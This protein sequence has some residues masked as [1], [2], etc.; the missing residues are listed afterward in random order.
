MSNTNP[1]NAN[2]VGRVPRTPLLRSDGRLTREAQAFLSQLSTELLAATG[3]S[4]TASAGGATLPAAPAGFLD[5]V[6]NGTSV[7]VPFYNP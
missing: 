7:K 5:L 1:A 6:V 4:S 2:A 3:S